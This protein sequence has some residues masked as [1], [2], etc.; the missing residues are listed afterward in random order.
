MSLVG[1]LTT[2]LASRVYNINY[3]VMNECRAF[4]GMEGTKV[5]GQNLPKCHFARQES[6]MN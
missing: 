6:T 4:G 2:L 5:L 3:R 1:Y